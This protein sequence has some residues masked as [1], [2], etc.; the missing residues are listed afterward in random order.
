[1]ILAGSA[2]QGSLADI[3]R[4]GAEVRL[5]AALGQR[6]TVGRIGFS[7]RPRPAFT[8]SDIRIGGADQAAPSIHLDRIQVFPVLWF[9]RGS[10]H[11]T[12]IYLDGFTVSLLR[13]AGGRW[14]VPS[15]FP[16][17]TRNAQAGI[18]I[19]RVR[20]VRGRLLIFDAT[21]GG[22]RETSRIDEIRTDMV[23]EPTACG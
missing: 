6:V 2:W 9:L 21:G 14:R 11:I 3:V 13:D 12:E 15:V 10:V 1:V 8:G 16:A 18:G 4:T 5:S 23:I 19:D 22:L 7:F 20:I 17:P